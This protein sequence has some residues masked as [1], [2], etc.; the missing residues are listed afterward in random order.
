MCRIVEV[1][2]ECVEIGKQRTAVG[3][4]LGLGLSEVPSGCF[5]LTA[6]T[7][8]KIYNHP[9]RAGMCS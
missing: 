4:L 8:V 7:A 3:N 1:K 6:G 9:Q 2:A 5:V